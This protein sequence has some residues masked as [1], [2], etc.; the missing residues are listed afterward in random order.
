MSFSLL[1]RYTAPALTDIPPGF[2]ARQGIE[3][4]MLD[5]D[6][7]IVPYTTDQPTPRVASWLVMVKDL[8]IH[9][10]VVSNSKNDRV[11][12]FCKKYR[13][14]CV[15]NAKKPFRRGIRQCLE[16]FD[17]EPGHA[18]LVGDQIFTDTLGANRCGVQSVLIEAI[19]NHNI[20]LRLRRKVEGP[21]RFMARKRRIDQ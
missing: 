16:R 9:V 18:M 21:F 8:Q 20:W 11:R 17:T 4:V 15:T 14:Y 12:R 7:T 1:P 5:F 10:C 2:L 19:D 3:L 6:N 13:L